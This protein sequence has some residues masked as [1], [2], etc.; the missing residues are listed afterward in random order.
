MDIED[1]PKTFIHIPA[2]PHKEARLTNRV[3]KRASFKFTKS[4]ITLPST[5]THIPANPITEAELIGKVSERQSKP[6]K[7]P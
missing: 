6:E 3:K 5:F 2:D 4:D 1:I 7:T